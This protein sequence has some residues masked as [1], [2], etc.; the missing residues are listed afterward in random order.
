MTIG[1]ISLVFFLFMSSVLSY[2]IVTKNSP[3]PVFVTGDINGLGK[4]VIESLVN[5]GIPVRVLVP[6]AIN[7]NLEGVKLVTTFVGESTDEEAVQS[8]MTGCIAA[9][10]MVK[11]A[12]DG[13]GS[14][15]LDYSGNSNVV[16]QVSICIDIIH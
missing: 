8:C 3:S 4:S 1:C 10:S 13:D 15:K 9:V 7:A 5:Q 16:E 2:I 14:S 12:T 6:K 11:G